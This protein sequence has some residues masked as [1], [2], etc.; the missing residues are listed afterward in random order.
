MD[1]VVDVL[2]IEDDPDDAD[3]AMLALRKSARI[4]SL[5][6]IDDGEEALRVLFDDNHPLPGVILLDLR[7]P[8]VDGIEILKAL[9]RDAHRMNIPV[10]A[11]ISSNEGKK[12]VESF[13]VNAD[14]YLTK[15]INV[16]KFNRALSDIATTRTGPFAK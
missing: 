15:P 5:K 3:L 16:E 2:L 12:Y 11:L 8:R 9:K 4:A 14:A 10:V 13:K 1:G 7:M 6:H